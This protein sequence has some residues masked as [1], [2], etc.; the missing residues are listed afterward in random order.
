MNEM[1][2]E[3]TGPRVSRARGWKMCEVGRD[4]YFDE[5]LTA[6]CSAAPPGLAEIG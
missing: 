4:E 1:P 2:V 5:F 3:F 6:A